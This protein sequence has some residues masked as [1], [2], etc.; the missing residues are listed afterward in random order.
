MAEVTDPSEA[1][2]MEAALCL[3]LALPPE[4][5]RDVEA[6]EPSRRSRISQKSL[7]ISTMLADEDEDG[8][9]EAADSE[10]GG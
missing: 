5:P 8:R 4:V 3:P 6:P 10:G 1:L 2:E 9:E 7:L